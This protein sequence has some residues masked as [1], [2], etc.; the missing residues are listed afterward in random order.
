MEL[1]LV[2]SFVIGADAAISRLIPVRMRVARFVCRS[3]F[4][5]VQTVL[6]VALIGSPVHPFFR[7][8]D[9]PHKF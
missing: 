8:E 7:P 6:I 4:F 1:S 3:I 5:A 2:F 9:L